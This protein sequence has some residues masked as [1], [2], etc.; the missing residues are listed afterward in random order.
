MDTAVFSGSFNPLHIG[1]LA[2]LRVLAGM[3]DKVLLVVSPVNPL[4]PSA[5]AGDAEQRLQ[6]ARAA[7]SRHPELNGSS[8]CNLSP[9]HH[10]EDIPEPRRR[11]EV[12]DIE[13][14]LPLPN[15]TVNT[16]DALKARSPQDSFTLVVGGDQIADFRRWRDY[17][18]ILTD[19]GVAVFPRDGFDI[20]AIRAGLLRE[21]P[22]YRIRLIDMPPVNISST[23]IREVL[24][25]GGDVSGL[26]M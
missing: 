14:S 4:K 9:E 25:E 23:R 16:L 18:R 26:K 8:S 13:F 6:A 21:N 19:Y 1:H 3:Y 20:G 15:Y 17:G 10:V 12:S 11:V 5:T 2:I 22:H 7:L 24:A